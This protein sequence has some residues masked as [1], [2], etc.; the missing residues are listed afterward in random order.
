MTQGDMY[1]AII[2]DH[3]DPDTLHMVRVLMTFEMSPIIDEDDVKIK[4]FAWFFKC[5][6]NEIEL[7]DG[8]IADYTI[9]VTL[10]HNIVFV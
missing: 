6:M 1:I 4:A 5:P 3:C 10:L 9:E 2:R 8:G 7:D